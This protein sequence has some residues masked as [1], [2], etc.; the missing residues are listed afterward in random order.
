MKVLFSSVSLLLM[1]CFAA[2][3]QYT[4]TPGA[5]LPALPAAAAAALDPAGVQIVNGGKVW[6]ELWFAKSLPTGE[7]S[8]EE[9]VALPTVPH[10]AFLGVVRFPA[11]A[12]DRRG[13]PV[14]PGVYAMRYSLYPADGNHMGA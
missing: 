10:G 3:P 5:A 7:K 6:C 4:M 14:K 9:S 12:Q 2:F 11:P 8:S 1:A 13:N